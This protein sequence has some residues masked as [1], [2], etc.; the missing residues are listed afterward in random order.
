MK[1]IALFLIAILLIVG[2]LRLTSCGSGF[3]FGGGGGNASGG[4]GNAS[5][6]QATE[7]SNVDTETE[8]AE[9]NQEASEEICIVVKQ[10][11]YY[12]EDEEVQLTRIK[13]LLTEKE[14]SNVI[15]E[16]NYAS[17]KTWDD[18]KK[19]LSELDIAAVEK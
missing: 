9:D 4:N 14:Y 2:G 16:N 19:L 6:E 11:S 13:S 17:K 10:D 15:I 3:G 8:E 7:P 5:S 1:K 12:I 18:L